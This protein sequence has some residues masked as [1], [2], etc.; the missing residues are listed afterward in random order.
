MTSADGAPEP[1]PRQVV[2]DYLAANDLEVEE[3]AD[4]FFSFSLPGEK[5]LQTA[6]RLD[7]GTHALGVHAFVC[8][9]PDENHEGVYRW[10]LQRNLRMYGVAFALDRLGDIYLDARLP[11]GM[12]TPDELDRLLGSVLTYA[13]ESFNAILEL[14]FASSIRKEW[15]WRT[16]RGEPTHNL[17]AFRGWLE[18]GAESG[19]E[20]GAESG[21]E[22]GQPGSGPDGSGQPGS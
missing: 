12:V 14:G 17:E 1:D 13:D 16:L 8:R 15:E 3:V 11:L 18:S 9:N 7:I 5:K 10:L 4:G 20:S 6:V 2:R 22:S 19:P 21:A